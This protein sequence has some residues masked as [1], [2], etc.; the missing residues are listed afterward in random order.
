MLLSTTLFDAPRFETC[1]L[2]PPSQEDSY[3]EGELAVPG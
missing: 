2:H 3:A 1:N